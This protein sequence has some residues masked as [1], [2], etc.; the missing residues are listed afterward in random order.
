MEGCGWDV[1]LKGCA[2]VKVDGGGEVQVISGSGLFMVVAR[3]CV[4]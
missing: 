1:T 3:I 4:W 2:R